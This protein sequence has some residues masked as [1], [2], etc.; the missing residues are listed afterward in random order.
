MNK[1]DGLVVAAF[2]PMQEDGSINLEMVKPLYKYYRQN[3]IKGVFLNGSTGEG[4]SL[5]Y[6][7]R[8]ELCEEWS[9]VVDTDFK[10]IVHIG[11]N[12]L[13]EAKEFAAHAGKNGVD[14][15]S[16]IGPFYQKSSTVEIL[17]EICAQVAAQVSDIPFYYYHIPVLTGIDFS[18]VDFMK[19]ASEKIPT[20]AGLKFT[21]SDLSE[22]NLCRVFQN[23]KYDMLYGNDEMYLAGLATGAKGFIGSTYNLFPGLYQEIREAFENNRMDRARELQVKAIQFVKVLDKYNYN[24]ASKAAMKMIGVDCGA[25]RL[26]FQTLKDSQISNLRKDLE[27]CG[28]FDYALMAERTTGR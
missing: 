7:E 13:N 20:L 18:M 15:I 1:I 23:G 11:S 10:L 2:T 4:L 22:Y 8:L 21:A 17:V 28:F 14:G 25:S 5:T 27:E 12:S 26:P 16:T 3:G 24:A 19:H 6:K 9:R